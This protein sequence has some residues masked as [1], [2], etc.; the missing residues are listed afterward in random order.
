MDDM[1]RIGV[2]TTTHGL[3]GEVKVFPTTED[4][5]RFKKCDEVILITKQG[6]L[7][8]HVEHVKFFKN[9]VIVKFKEFNDIN[10]VETFRKCDLM[11]T[12][13]NA[14][15]LA[16]GEYYLYDVIGAKVIDDDSEEEIGVIRDVM[17]TGANDV[18]VIDTKDGTEVLFPSIPDCIKKVDTDAGIVRAHVM[19]GLMDL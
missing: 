18:F 12:R 7:T 17:E 14:V 6:N 1:L 10:E 5:K 2:V 11:V 3:R 8:L 9:I 19:K 16:E 13:E 15:P 4:P